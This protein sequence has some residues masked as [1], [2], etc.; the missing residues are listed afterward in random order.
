MPYV[1]KDDKKNFHY[2][3]A[4]KL[5]DHLKNLVPDDHSNAMKERISQLETENAKLKL[6]KDPVP[7]PKKSR[8]E[9]FVAISKPDGKPPFLAESV[10]LSVKAKDMKDWVKT[11]NMSEKDR[12]KVEANIKEL[13]SLYKSFE[14][15]EKLNLVESMVVEWGLPIS[16]AA[17]WDKQ[18]LISLMAFAHAASQ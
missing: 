3:L 4:Q 8:H 12:K 14:A 9:D 5:F 2:H 13:Q 7:T 17:T 18:G 6:S 10:P 1:S 16:Q 15:Q 11:L